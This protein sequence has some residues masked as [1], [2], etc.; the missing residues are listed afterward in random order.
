MPQITI[1]F[2]FSTPPTDGQ[3]IVYDLSSNSFIA[4]SGGGG[5]STDV[6]NTG[7]GDAALVYQTGTG[8]V[9]VAGLNGDSTT[10][11]V[12]STDGGQTATV[13][14]KNTS[15]VWNASEFLGQPAI[16]SGLADLDGW[17]YNNSLSQWE[18]RPI[19]NS[20]DSPASG[21]TSQVLGPTGDV[22]VKDI[23]SSDDSIS[24]SSGVGFT[25][26]TVPIID[27]ENTV[28][29]TSFYVLSNPGLAT[30]GIPYSFRG[31][32]QIGQDATGRN[33]LN[34]TQD[35]TNIYANI[36]PE[37]VVTKYAFSVSTASF[38]ASHA[39]AQLKGTTIAANVLNTNGQELR[40]NM[41]GNYTA[42]ASQLTVN[43]KW[44]GAT[45][46]T[47]P[48]STLLGAATSSYT[49]QF[50]IKRTGTTSAT[51]FCS[52]IGSDPTNVSPCSATVQSGMD[53]TVTNVMEI[54][55]S[56][57]SGATISAF[58]HDIYLQ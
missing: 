57:G 12:T 13:A 35:A 29:I 50:T 18:N 3:A 46:Y 33:F 6:E 15:A 31:L 8:T 34:W 1:P 27:L 14:A 49:L 22:Q 20:I 39:L 24:V 55:A 45:I 23:G 2:D 56:T 7:L 58:G 40:F 37:V 38:G 42:T 25:D 54:T 30:T 44:G 19:V 36:N 17:V 51:A 26:L 16:N 52:F 32:N 5:G 43:F 21:Y 9:L 4:G 48:T 53:F 41:T 11:T 28:D 47:L 10:T